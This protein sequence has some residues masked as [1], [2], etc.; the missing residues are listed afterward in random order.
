MRSGTGDPALG[1]GR[2]IDRR[3]FLDGVALAIG[4]LGVG[5]AASTAATATATTTA[6]AAQAQ[7]GYYPPLLTGL[8]GSHPGSFDDAHALRDGTLAA[9]PVTDTGETYDLIVVGGGISGLAAARFWRDARPD[10]RV[11][12]LDNHDD[13]G[14]HAK[15]NEFW[16]DGKL[17]LMNG[18]TLLIDSPRPYG[19][20]PAALL[21]TLKIDPVAL[22]KHCMKPEIYAGLGHGVFFDRSTFGADR[23]VGNAPGGRFDGD[24]A[25]DPVRQWQAFLAATP[26]GEVARRDILRIE[27]GTEDLLAGKSDAAKKDQLSRISYADYLTTIAHAD[28][29]VPPFYQA[30]THSEWAVGIDAVSALD[31]WGFGMSGFAGLKLDPKPHSRMSFTP[32]GYIEGGSTTFHFPDGNATIARLLVRRLV[33]GSLPGSTATDAVTARCDYATLDRPSNGVRLRLSSIVIGAKHSGARRVTVTYLRAGNAFSVRAG[34]VVMAG[35]NA[36]IPYLIP[37]LPERQK[38]ALHSL[39]KAPLVYTTVALRNWQPFKTAG[40]KTIHAPGSFYSNLM[41][42][43][44]MDIGNYA[45]E[46]DPSRPI[47]AMLTRTPCAPGLSSD[48][49]NRAGRAELLAMPFATFERETRTQLAAMIPGLDPARDITAITVNRWPHG[50]APEYNYLWQ[51]E[52]APAEMPHIVGRQRFGRIAIANSDAGNGAYTDVAIEQG[53]RAV[54]ELLGT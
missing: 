37:E 15:R 39:V 8:R 54:Q 48:D 30:S 53:H 5:G 6:M 3:D 44:P 28:A 34:A 19:P 51:P 16:L 14:G 32:A 41:L 42:N 26:L 45:A 22:T 40:V 25:P 1:I 36:M 24:A 29:S 2:P 33:P 12:V 50:Y 46:R 11:L 21:A 7:S 31:A 47:L 20:A 49:Q 18:G 27:T 13:F 9:A 23:L 35:Y 4:A 52:V 10:A 38:T 17:H 43:W